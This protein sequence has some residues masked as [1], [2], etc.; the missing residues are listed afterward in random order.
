ME[1]QLVDNPSMKQVSSTGQNSWL[2]N[3]L[4]NIKQNFV[5]SFNI[6]VSTPDDFDIEQFQVTLFT[7]PQEYANLTSGSIINWRK[8]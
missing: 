5:L 8:C 6:H 2:T 7:S 3:S 1:K 4:N